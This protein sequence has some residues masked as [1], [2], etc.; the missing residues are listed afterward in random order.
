MN[1]GDVKHA[2]EKHFMGLA[3]QVAWW[4]WE[5]HW[6]HFHCGVYCPIETKDPVRLFGLRLCQLS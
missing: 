5:F 4:S 6:L 3:V 1:E 2:V